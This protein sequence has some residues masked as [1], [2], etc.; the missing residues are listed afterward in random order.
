M[1]NFGLDFLDW[2]F[3]IGSRTRFVQIKT[4]VGNKRETISINFIQLLKAVSV[5]VAIL[6]LVF[7]KFAL[8]GL[9][10]LCLAA[11]VADHCTSSRYLVKSD[12]KYL[13]QSTK[14]DL[15]DALKKMK[16]VASNYN[17]SLNA[18]DYF[19]ITHKEVFDY[20]VHGYW[21]FT[22]WHRELISRFD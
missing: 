22:P 8:L 5:T 18:Y 9:I 13:S 12:A 1:Q 19:V 2:I 21:L 7:M 6:S 10:A 3:W 11:I 20:P 14:D 16:T 4:Q 17:S 15:V